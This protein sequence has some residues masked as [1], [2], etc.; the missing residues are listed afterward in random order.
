[1]TLDLLFNTKM[2]TYTFC[3]LILFSIFCSCIPIKKI[4]YSEETKTFYQLNRNKDYFNSITITNQFGEKYDTDS[5]CKINNDTIYLYSSFYELKKCTIRIFSSSRPE[6]RGFKYDYMIFT[7]SIQ[8]SNYKN[9][10]IKP[11]F[12]S[13]R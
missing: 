6:G 5:I 3:I 12:V 9:I 13:V 2:R 10:K 4:G 11:I 1:M 7:D 8:I